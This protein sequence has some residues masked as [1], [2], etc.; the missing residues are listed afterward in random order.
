MKI[1]VGNLPDCFKKNYLLIAIARKIE[2]KNALYDNNGI[3]F[4]SFALVFYFI[5]KR[6]F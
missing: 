1:I 2:I 3:C 4:L 6:L 5:G